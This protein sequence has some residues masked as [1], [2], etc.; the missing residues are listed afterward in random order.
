MAG[1]DYGVTLRQSERS[2]SAANAVLYAHSEHGSS[3]GP[4]ILQLRDW[5][6]KHPQIILK[7][8]REN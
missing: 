7:S 8:F 3:F 1:R 6:V 5:A 2:V 4:I